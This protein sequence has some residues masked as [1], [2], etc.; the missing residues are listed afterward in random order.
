LS[1]NNENITNNIKELIMTKWAS[2]YIIMTIFLA[3]CGSNPPPIPPTLAPTVEQVAA[4]PTFTPETVQEQAETTN[5]AD[6]VLGEA[7]TGSFSAII[8]GDRSLSFEGGGTS[9]CTPNNETRIGSGTASTGNSMFF[10]I[11]VGTA[12]GE[13]TLGTA[14]STLQAVLTVEETRYNGESFGILTLDAMPT[15]AGESAVGSFDMNFVSADGVNVNVVGS[16]NVL[17]N[18]IC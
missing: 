11:P 14:D 16:F 5:N 8:T 15:V 12:T 7:S 17:I 10:R 18:E 9:S 3:A 6:I 4:P 1:H 13:Y 2:L